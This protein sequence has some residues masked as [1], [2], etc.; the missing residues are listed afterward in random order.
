MGAATSLMFGETDPSIACMVLDSAYS[1]LKV[2][3]TEL[4]Q[5]A[6]VWNHSLSWSL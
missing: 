5:Q 4:T 3:A 1:S 2:L 6:E